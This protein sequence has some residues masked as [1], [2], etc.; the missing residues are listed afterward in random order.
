MLKTM[1][2]ILFT[3]GAP[4]ALGHGVGG[5]HAIDEAEAKEKAVATV[6]ELVAQGKVE[7]VWKTKQPKVEKKRFGKKK[8]WVATFENAE[9][10]DLTKKRLYVYLDMEGEFVAA[11]H[12]GK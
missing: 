9:S 1:I 6:A 7:A 10:K 5:H 2:A 4:L 3:L 8:E 12:T 11:N